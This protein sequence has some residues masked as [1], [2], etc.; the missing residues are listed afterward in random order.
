MEVP[1]RITF[2]DMPPSPAVE[3]NIRERAARF[4]EIYDHVIGC[5]VTVEAPHRHHHKGKAAL[6]N[7]KWVALRHAD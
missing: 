7:F 6:I 1:L 3:A 5:H 2:R 4:D